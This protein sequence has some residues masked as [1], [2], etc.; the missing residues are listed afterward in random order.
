MQNFSFYFSATAS[1]VFAS[2]SLL[3]Q[4]SPLLNLFHTSGTNVILERLIKMI[5]N[6]WENFDI[7]KNFL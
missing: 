4:F 6:C 5:E 1:A 7:F 2:T 3:L